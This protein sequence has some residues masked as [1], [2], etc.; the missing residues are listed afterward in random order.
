MTP[1]S[2]S[3][4]IAL[5]LVLVVTATSR[6]AYACSCDDLL[7]TIPSQ[8]ERVPRNARL[9]V[10]ANLARDLTILR[11]R[12]RQPEYA[13]RLQRREQRLSASDVAAFFS[14]VGPATQPLPF[15]VHELEL[16]LE[17]Y[18]IVQPREGMTPGLHVFR[19][20]EALPAN[21]EADFGRLDVR[22]VV[23]DV[24]LNERPERPR[25]TVDKW[26][27]E[28]PEAMCA[29]ET[30]AVLRIQHSGKLL[31]YQIFDPRL[32]ASPP[33]TAEYRTPDQDF[34]IGDGDCI[35]H[36]DFKRGPALARFGTFDIVGRFSG[37]GPPILLRPQPSLGA[38]KVHPPRAVTGH[39]GCGCRLVNS[40]NH[41]LTTPSLLGF[42]AVLYLV[43][44][45]R[46]S[47]RLNTRRAPPSARDARLR[48]R[49]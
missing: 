26:I 25:V 28:E 4:L 45:R 48:R 36:W 10:T 23:E 12:D 19:P 14:L 39:R 30:A 33:E 16:G 35:P 5:S 43:R 29:S 3:K 38:K 18:F 40:Q 8:N 15:G 11:L 32:A 6:H 27:R 9:W 37:W 20:R 46:R 13:E 34:W 47:A 21:L 17:A 1:Y 7:E 49:T 31:A 41:R 2:I 44:S 42:V 24:S 22:F